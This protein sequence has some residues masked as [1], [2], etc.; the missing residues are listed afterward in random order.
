MSKRDFNIY[1]YSDVETSE[2]F[3][4]TLENKGYLFDNEV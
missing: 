2:S 4:G 3:W 1:A